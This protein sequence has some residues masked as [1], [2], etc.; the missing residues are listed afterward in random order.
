MKDKKI[1][2]LKEKGITLIALVVTIIILL[3]LAGVTLN[4]AINGDGLF[5]KARNAADKYKKAQED[6]QELISQIG[7]EMYSEYVG[8][9][10]TGY[11]FEPKT[12]ENPFSVGTDISGAKSELKFTTQTDMEWKIWDYDGT[13]LRIISDR[14]TT[15]KLQL[16][17][18]NGYNNGVWVINEIC[19]QCYGQYEADG[20]TKKEGISVANLKR[21]DIEKVSNYDCTKYKHQKGNPDEIINDY[22][23]ID[24]IHYGEKKTYSGR[25]PTMWKK[26]DVEW[27]YEYDT[28]RKIGTGNSSCEIPWEKEYTTD[29]GGGEENIMETDEFRESYYSHDFKKNEFI[30]DKYY[31]II[32]KIPDGSP[33]GVYWLASRFVRLTEEEVFFGCS[34]VN[35]ISDGTWIS[36]GNSVCQKPG[37]IGSPNEMLRPIVSI[38]LTTSGYS[39]V[40]DGDQ[41]KLLKDNQ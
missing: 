26:H 3:I 10:V 35:S 9:K 23:D 17:N 11:N 33:A 24:L 7:K 27:N 14:P 32:F 20:E 38:D 31:D 15:Q 29:V 16:T 40:K 1:Q 28:T 34:V 8:A 2:A 21:S 39:I 6:E 37:V 30:N 19:R 18:V 13:T 5:S 41:Y 36:G 12:D 25:V 4:M 22:D